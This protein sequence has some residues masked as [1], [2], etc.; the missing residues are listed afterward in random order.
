MPS[1]ITEIQARQRAAYALLKA[2]H[3]ADAID[4]TRLPPEEAEAGRSLATEAASRRRGRP[5]KADT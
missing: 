2:L 5:P 4:W 3:Q 1:R